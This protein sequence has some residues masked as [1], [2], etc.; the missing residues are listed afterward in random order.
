MRYRT[1]IIGLIIGL[2]C[3]ILFSYKAGMSLWVIF[4][5]LAV[6]LMISMGLSRVRAELGPAIHEIFSLD[7]GRFLFTGFGSRRIGVA[8]L[9]VLSFY[10]WLNRVYV[11]HPMPNQLEAFKIA[12]RATINPRRLVWVMMFATVFGVLACFWSY[13]HVMYQTGANATHGSVIGVGREVFTRLGIRLD[14]L[15]GTDFPAVKAYGL[16]FVITCLLSL[17]TYLW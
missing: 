5:F 4:A 7:P 15:S 6:Y 13:L 11:A 3:L 14:S 16:G 1:A 2:V 17:I 9:T 8:S 12:Q 10:Y